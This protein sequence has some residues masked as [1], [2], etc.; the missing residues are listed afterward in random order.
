M[1]YVV[2]ALSVLANTV[3]QHKLLET[4]FG[5]LALSSATCAQLLL[6]IV[7]QIVISA[8]RTPG[9]P[10]NGM[11]YRAGRLAGPPSAR[12]DMGRVRAGIFPCPGRARQAGPE[13]D[14]GRARAWP[15][16]PDGLPLLL[17]C[18]PLRSTIP[19]LVSLSPFP[20]SSPKRSGLHP[21][22][23]FKLLQQTIQ[24]ESFPLVFN[25]HVPSSFALEEGKSPSEGQK[26]PNFV[27]ERAAFREPH[28]ASRR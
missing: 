8:R 26:S 19:L 24:L 18:P 23:R 5:R 11:F 4:P 25:F 15:G 3:I 28:L 14:P 6:S 2:P 16:R 22:K 20:S 9:C 1:Y 10:I 17:S 7:F 13:T 12:P 27:L 21:L